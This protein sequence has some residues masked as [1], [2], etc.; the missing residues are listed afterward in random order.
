VTNCCEH[1]AITSGCNQGRA[2]P[3]RAAR[4]SGACTPEPEDQQLKDDMVVF[5]VLVILAYTLI[6]GALGYLWGIHGAAIEAFLWALAAKL[7]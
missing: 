4:D 5:G 7:S 3:V 1:H 6:C 2:C